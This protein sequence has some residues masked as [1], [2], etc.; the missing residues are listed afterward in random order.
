MGSGIT[1]KGKHSLNFWSRNR[2]PRQHMVVM[3]RI[4][5]ICRLFRPVFIY[6]I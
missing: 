3:N 5:K 4:A 1:N 2:T 6:K